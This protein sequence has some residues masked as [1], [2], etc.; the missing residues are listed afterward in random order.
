MV[1][2]RNKLFGINIAV[3]NEDFATMIMGFLPPS[4]CQLLSNISA[5]AKMT[6]TK[7]KPN[8][9][10]KFINE[11]V[12]YRA[13]DSAGGPG[14]AALYVSSTS[15]APPKAKG[16]G[17]GKKKTCTN[18]NCKRE[19]HLAADCWRPRG[20]KEG[21]GP[22]QLAKKAEAVK[23]SANLAADTSN[24]AFTCSSDFATLAQSLPVPK[25]RLGAIVD[26]GASTLR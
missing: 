1:M 2:A 23:E 22:R 6:G 14:N 21:Q 17:K 18:P 8:E 25:E 13:H 9:L 12:E 24:F 20:G 10:I 16:K 26:S 7:I 3:P 4:Y 19:G 11:E 5:A 15:D